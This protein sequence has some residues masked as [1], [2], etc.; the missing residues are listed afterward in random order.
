MTR[1]RFGKGEAWYIAF[2]SYDTFLSDLYG[3]LIKEYGIE[4]ALETDLPNGVTA[5]IRE[6]EAHRFCFLQNYSGTKQTVELPHPMRDLLSGE[7]IRSAF[8][9]PYSYRVLS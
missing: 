6:D 2:R 8:M 3:D 1:N 7:T 5:A 4:R 9:A